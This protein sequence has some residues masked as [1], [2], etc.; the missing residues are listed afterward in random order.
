MGQWFEKVWLTFVKVKVTFIKVKSTKT[1]SIEGKTLLQIILNVQLWVCSVRNNIQDKRG[2]SIGFV[3]LAV[4]SRWP[5]TE[6]KC[7]VFCVV[8]NVPNLLVCIDAPDMFKYFQSIHDMTLY[9]PS[10][11]YTRIHHIPL[12]SYSVRDYKGQRSRLSYRYF[13]TKFLSI[14]YISLSIIA[15]VLIIGVSSGLMQPYYTFWFLLISK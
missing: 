3:M 11:K 1:G 13:L 7:Q 12:E 5:W 14:A 10:P 9:H 15:S 4:T 2:I 8:H 6:V